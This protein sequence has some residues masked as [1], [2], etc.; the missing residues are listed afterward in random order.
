M[1]AQVRPAQEV[2]EAHKP[3]SAGLVIGTN[4]PA[5]QVSNA[6]VIRA[7]KTQSGVEGG[8]RFHKD[9]W[10][11]VSALVVKKPSRIQG[12]LLGMTL[13]WRVYSLTQ[14]RWRQP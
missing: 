8:C 14:R 6:E 2:L 9:P 4:I 11:L 12:L 7:F 1:H 10:L 13:A 5:C 3:Q